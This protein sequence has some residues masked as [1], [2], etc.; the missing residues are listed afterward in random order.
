M[1]ICEVHGT[2]YRKHCVGC[3]RDERQEIRAEQA[4]SEQTKKQ[5][6]EDEE[7]TEGFLSRMFLRK[8]D[9]KRDIENYARNIGEREET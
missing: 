6:A 5:T 3:T 2:R 4:I 7:K 9:K 1:K 8:K